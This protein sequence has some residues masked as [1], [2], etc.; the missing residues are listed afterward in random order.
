MSHA[1]RQTRNKAQ[2]IKK[3]Q[4][5]YDSEVKPRK[6]WAGF[7]KPFCHRRGTIRPARLNKQFGGFVKLWKHPPSTFRHAKMNM[8]DPPDPTDIEKAR[9]WFTKE[10]V[11]WGLM[12]DF[13]KA[14]LNAGFLQQRVWVG[15]PR[16]C[17]L[18]GDQRPEL[19]SD[20]L[21]D[22]SS[23]WDFYFT[24]YDPHLQHWAGVV[25]TNPLDKA[26]V[27]LNLKSKCF[28]KVLQVPLPSIWLRHL[29]GGP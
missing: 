10:F 28:F 2:E 24:D 5:G 8:P 12:S 29:E 25:G 27:C 20:E 19:P 26:R 6:D 11:Q 14:K 15:G 22:Y 21:L 13:R 18:K 3:A 9:K 16:I 23:E 1:D 7:N 4:T 17:D